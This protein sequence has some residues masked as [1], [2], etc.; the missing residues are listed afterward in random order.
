VTK[1]LSLEPDPALAADCAFCRIARGE[2]EAIVVCDDEDCIAFFPES[3]ATPGH[4]LVI[5]RRHVQHF[6]QVDEP[7]GERLMSMVSRVG[8]AIEKALRPE[9]MNLISS[10]GSAATQTVPHLH[11]HVVPRWS[12]DAIGDI[13]PPKTPM[14]EALEEDLAERIRG[15]C[16]DS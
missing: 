6:L 13:W 2:E 14:E 3:P 16:S 1:R 9:G 4:T 7:L 15:A 12:T 10:A 11:L 8:G 5:P